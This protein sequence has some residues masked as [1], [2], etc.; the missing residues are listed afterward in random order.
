MA[1]GTKIIPEEKQIEFVDEHEPIDIYTSTGVKLIHHPHALTMWKMGYGTP[2]SLQAG[3]TSRCN[4]NCVFCSNANREKH[5]DL[6]I[7]DIGLLLYQLRGIGLRTVEWTGGGDPTMYEHINEAISLASH[8]RLEQ[9]M[10]TNGILLTKN[11]RWDSLKSLKWLRVSMNS[12]DYVDSVTIP[13][14]HGTLGF[15]Y[16]WNEK[17]DEEVLGRIADHVRIYNPKYVRIVPDCQATYEEQEE[18]NA[19]LSLVVRK[20]GHPYFYQ[21]KHFSRPENCWWCY[22]KPF[23]LHDGWVYPCSSVVLNTTS[24]R[25][26]HKNFRWVKMD[27]LVEHYK[28]KVSPFDPINC[29]HCVFRPQNDLCSELRNPNEMCN[30]V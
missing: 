4:L 19:K 16:C 29:D 12:L 13:L 8:L 2:I 17:T 25:T 7:R 20:M 10:I 24:E 6:D 18:N 21:A 23:L 1:W 9:G 3:P 28:R 30:F 26:F 5:E 22:W 27:S 15:S 14:F 11:M